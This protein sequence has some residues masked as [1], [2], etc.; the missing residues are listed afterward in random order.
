MIAKGLLLPNFRAL[1]AST[2]FTPPSTKL[3]PLR[4]GSRNE[5]IKG[6]VATLLTSLRRFSFSELEGTYLPRMTAN[7]LTLRSLKGGGESR[8]YLKKAQNKMKYDRLPFE[9]GEESAGL[10]VKKI[11]RKS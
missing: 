9:H 1:P 6:E 11:S 10:R 8:G 7:E 2:Y 5:G 4:T 3:P